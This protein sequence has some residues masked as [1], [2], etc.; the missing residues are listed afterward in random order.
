MKRET[1]EWIQ[2]A[3][4][5]FQAAEHLLKKSLFRIEKVSNS[6]ENKKMLETLK[7]FASLRRKQ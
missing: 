4:E 5:D 2:I 7:K 6:P 3:E 1:E